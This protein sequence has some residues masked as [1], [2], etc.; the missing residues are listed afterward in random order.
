M[1]VG[2]TSGA[3][4]LTVTTASL[5]DLSMLVIPTG[6]EL[7]V[8]GALSGLRVSSV[9]RM[10]GGSAL[11]LADPVLL[12]C[13]P[14]ANVSTGSGSL[15]AVYSGSIVFPLN[16]VSGSR[17]SGDVLA[18]STTSITLGATP[19]TGSIR[20]RAGELTLSCAVALSSLSVAAIS[21]SNGGAL[22]LAAANAVNC[23]SLLVRG[24][25]VL[26]TG[27]QFQ[28]VSGVVSVTSDR[29]ALSVDSA[30]TLELSGIA[31]RTNQLV[32]NL[33]STSAAGNATVLMRRNAE[34]IVSGG[35][36]LV[37][38]AGPVNSGRV[39]LFTTVQSAARFELN[40]GSPGFVFASGAGGSPAPDGSVIVSMCFL[41]AGAAVPPS[42]VINEPAQCNK[43]FSQPCQNGG[44]CAS[45]FVG[46]TC[47]CVAGYSGVNCQTEINECASRPCMN[48]GTCTDH[49][50][51][52]SCLCASGFV[53]TVCE[54][55]VN[56]CVSGPCVNGAT[57]MD[58]VN[59]FTCQCV[60]GYTGVLCQ[61]EINE[62]APNPCV[63]GG[64]CADGINS[65]VCSCLPGYGGLQCQTPP[66]AC[67][68]EPCENGGVCNNTVT[69]ASGFTCRC[70]T[71][72]DGNKCQ[73]KC[74]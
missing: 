40:S 37:D 9:L 71:G 20:T 19:L 14:A 6:G 51:S 69:T 8:A 72:F 3:A 34:M 25:I 43:C 13:Q 73:C 17:L 16:P 70:R 66:P 48:G 54:T 29:V 32:V 39:V 27:S 22:N 18:L 15:I 35:S 62:C 38:G 63:N 30:A 74:V 56:E 50:N 52:F 44:S 36:V 2:P 5:I 57:C 42:V 46:Y 23:P 64:S 31:V 47:M 4:N 33:T 49:L 65:Y 41:T 67:F 59:Q 12:M 21:V 55:N 53:G 24:E 11:A 61:T 60:P 68:Y 7:N 28:T 26:G 1:V 45:R 10:D 58:G